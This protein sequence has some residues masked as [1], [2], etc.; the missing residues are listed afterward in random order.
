MK[1]PPMTL[2]ARVKTRREELGLAI[3]AA[4]DTAGVSE[5]RWRQIE[6]GYQSAAAGHRLPVRPGP[7]VL[8]SMA[9]TLDLDPDELLAL[10]S[11]PA[12][13]LESGADPIR[14]AIE[15]DTSLLPEAKRHLLNQVG[16]L[17]R[18]SP[19]PISDEEETQI[20]QDQSQLSSAMLSDLDVK[21]AEKAAPRKRAA[22]RPR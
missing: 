19:G 15:E 16:L 18:L 13:A 14:Q 12:P 21:R 6:K 7:R 11:A 1:K 5:G 9:Q 2:G 3:R 20:E 8:R 10:A 22:K 17:R 4:A